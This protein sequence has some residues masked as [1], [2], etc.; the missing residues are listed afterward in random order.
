MPK[1]I[2]KSSLPTTQRRLKIIIPGISRRQ[3]FVFPLLPYE[4][5][6]D[7]KNTPRFT[8][9]QLHFLTTKRIIRTLSGIF[10]VC[11]SH[12]MQYLLAIKSRVKPNDCFCLILK[13][14]LFG[15]KR[16]P[17]WKIWSMLFPLPSRKISVKFHLLFLTPDDQDR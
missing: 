3:P 12:T 17:S 6:L 16:T 15:T 7:Y 13:I 2:T 14:K 9:T 5:K 8:W 1:G 10:Y 11:R 4:T